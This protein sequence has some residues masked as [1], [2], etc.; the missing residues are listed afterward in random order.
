MNYKSFLKSSNNKFQVKKAHIIHDQSGFSYIS[1]PDDTEENNKL[2]EHLIPC[3]NS[4]I[5][6]AYSLGINELNNN[7]ISLKVDDSLFDDFNSTNFNMP[8]KSQIEDVKKNGYN[9]VQ[10][11]AYLIDNKFN[12]NNK[13]EFI[14][15]R[16][17]SEHYSLLVNID[18]KPKSMSKNM[19]AILHATY[20]TKNIS[21]S[22]S[23]MIDIDTDACISS[24]S[25]RIFYISKKDRVL[26]EA[27]E[28]ERA[29]GST[30]SYTIAIKVLF[31]A[32]KIYLDNM[33]SYE[34]Y[35]VKFSPMEMFMFKKLY[36][37]HI[38]KN[39]SK[40]PGIPKTFKGMQVTSLNK[41]VHSEYDVYDKEFDSN[42]F[43]EYYLSKIPIYN[44]D[45]YKIKYPLIDFTEKELKFIEK[46]GDK[47]YNEDARVNLYSYLSN[48]P[49]GTG[50]RYKYSD[51]DELFVSWVINHDKTKA[52]ILVSELSDM[53][54]IPIIT[55]D[56]IDIDNFACGET[57]KQLMVGFGSEIVQDVDT[58]I[59]SINDIDILSI[60]KDKKECVNIICLLLDIIIVINERPQRSKMIKITKSNNNNNNQVASKKNNKSS[61][62]KSSN[63]SEYVISRILKP[64]KEAKEYVSRMN[65]IDTS[66]ERNYV[67]E[68]WERKGHYRRIHGTDRIIW[69]EA[70]TC[71][72]HKEL[73]KDKEIRIKL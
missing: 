48:F 65:S 62:N 29:I 15:L 21:K 56:L 70:T 14:I 23:F 38:N 28:S 1:Y 7:F 17:E 71:N 32:L 40:N 36:Q 31:M 52:R 10:E 8:D 68:S 19:I 53:K 35:Q 39:A 4:S 11:I 63:P 54:H 60:F 9:L 49:Y 64:A 50:F 43:A 26:E 27:I 42:N 30:Q 33:K 66:G 73:N 44:M 45:D 24:I 41:W 16:F 46:Y 22:Y 59:S 55:G 67:L 20:I 6:G 12:F 61:N 34:P 5:R 51:E 58:M 69:I 25:D 13:F 57:F 18:Y 3:I 2:I 72:R 47:K 37:N